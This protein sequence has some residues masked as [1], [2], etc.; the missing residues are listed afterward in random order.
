MR[1]SAKPLPFLLLLA[2][3]AT[4]PAPPREPVHVVVAATTDFHGYLEGRSSRRDGK[5]VRTGS[6]PLLAGYIDALRAA[7]GE[8]LLVIDG[9]DQWQGTLASNLD[10]GETVTR[11]FSA[12]GMNA[13]A[14]GNHDFDFGPLGEKGAPTSPSDDPV[15]ALRRNV[16]LANFPFLCTNITLRETGLPPQWCEPSLLVQTGD[17]TIGIL[18]VST[19]DTPALTQ[20]L[21]VAHLVFRDAAEAIVE[22]S[23]ELR[24]RGADAI[25]VAAHIGNIC[26]S[27]SDPMAASEQC[28]PEAPL[29]RLAERLPRGTVSLIAGGHTHNV[30]RHFVNGIALIQAPNHGQ[31]LAV[32]DLWVDPASN[33]TRVELRPHLRIC[34]SVADDGR[35]APEDE[36]G[37]APVVDGQTVTA[38][39][40]VRSIVAPAIESARARQQEPLGIT[41]AAPAEVSRTGESSLAN[42]VTR[43][44]LAAAPE[45]EV[46]MMNSGGLR[47][48]LD[49]GELLFGDIYRTFPFDNSLTLL[50][51]TGEQLLAIIRQAMID[52]PYG[53]MHFGGVSV[54]IDADTGALIRVTD[55]SG[56]AIDPTR[57]YDLVTIDFL[58][59]GGD[60]FADLVTAIDPAGIR[61]TGDLL[62]DVM[63]RD[64][65]RRSE[66][67]PVTPPTTGWLI[68][69]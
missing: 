22:R 54:T 16:S 37:T 47:A 8:R 9:G 26:E 61:L 44:M 55:S 53:I 58:A 19:E 6:L 11:A 35:C 23:R 25:I 67:G 51:V 56:N 66:A 42:L 33:Q 21:N 30:S 43:A 65:S 36:P 63:I 39:A 60:G 68:R 57:T 28:D 29:V 41:L 59:S 4:S 2:A 10:E 20:P 45:A 32:A 3:C 31:G 62:R 5:T 24:Q 34:E 27:T 12:M 69:E 7:H 64:L 52:E 14:L 38:S 48:T 17:A 18:G 50:E 40:E 46:A 15:G 13:T 1:G 49:Q